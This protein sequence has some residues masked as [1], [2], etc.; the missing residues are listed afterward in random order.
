MSKDT[1]AN[2]SEQLNL[3]IISRVAIGDML[4]RRARSDGQGD[5]IVESV[6]GERRA[7]TYARL[8]S[9]ANKIARGLRANGLRQGDRLALVAGNSS[10]F[11]AVMF[12]CFKAGIV[13]VPINYLQSPDDVTFNFEHG[14]VS[15]VIYD[16]ELEELCCK[17]SQDIDAIRFK[18]SLGDNSKYCDT[19]L[20]EIL[21]HQSDEEILDIM[22]DDRDTALV[23][24]TSGT[25]S[26]PKGVEVS[27]LALTLASLNNPLCF[28]FTR[29]GAH[30]NVLPT[31]HTTAIGNAL[32]TFQ[33]SGTFV[34][35]SGFN[36]TAVV[37]T[38]EEERIQ[39]VVLLPMMWSAL[40]AVPGVEERDYSALS[41]AIYAM[42]PMSAKTLTNLRKVFACDFH[43]G[44]G[45]T[46]FNPAPCI[47]YD[48]SPTEFGEGNYWGVP[49]IMS[50]QAVLDDNGRECEVGEVGE[51]C[52]RGP[53]SMNGYLKNPEA[54]AEVQT[55][56]WH[57]SGDLGFIDVEGQL[58]FVDRK[59]DIIKTGG[60]NVS[61]CKVEAA[62]VGLDAVALAAV[63]GV[64]HPKW[65]EAVCAVLQ[66]T[67]GSQLDESVA[68]SHCSEQL[69]RY[70]VPKKIIVQQQIALTSTGK[71]KKPE[72]RKEYSELFAEEC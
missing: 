2:S 27:H 28:G 42:A 55:F 49:T 52:W 30:L 43:L 58:M 26:R 33:L 21:A 66:L 3:N 22:I 8:N 65:G 5:A 31:F 41:S 56:A 45:Q 16:G 13:V 50:E 60:E 20:S 15:A 59:K 54:T 63:F 24:Y 47:F 4:R 72:L 7:T 69:A 19:T 71:V 14:E 48:H 18:L 25:T 70:E 38:L 9:D 34:I 64:P 57:H 1:E 29:G 51:I 53:Q 40:L 67:P 17:C 12:A 36:P 11:L 68:L 23:L 39:S 32:S 46:E 35:H 44:S 6:E 10:H 61:S 62:L 37:T